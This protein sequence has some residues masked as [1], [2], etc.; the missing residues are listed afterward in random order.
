MTT[1]D[2]VTTEAAL[3]WRAPAPDDLLA[4]ARRRFLRGE[5]LDMQ[6]LA[7]ELGISRATVYRWVGNA[8]QLAGRIVADLAEETFHLSLSQARG[9]GVARIIDAMERGMRYIVESEPYRRFLE[10]DPQTALRIVASKDGEPQGRMIALHERL[11]IEEV[12]VGN[13][14]L[15]VDAHAMA[16]ALVRTVESFVYADL[17]AGEEPD[18]DAAVEIL[19]LLL[20]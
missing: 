9:R 4:L 17:I 2:S 19:K 18:L 16:Y 15:S 11:L 8:E 12:A 20:R 3:T 14:M 5:R 6:A 13:L 1:G 10:R 7:A